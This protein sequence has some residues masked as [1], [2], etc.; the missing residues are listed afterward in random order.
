MT[1]LAELGIPLSIV[2]QPIRPLQ[3]TTAQAVNLDFLVGN[4]TTNQASGFTLSNPT[5]LA[6]AQRIALLLQGQVYSDP[7]QL[8]DLRAIYEN[9]FAPGAP[10]PPTAEPVQ[11][12]GGG[13]G[14]GAILA[15][16]VAA[17]AFGG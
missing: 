15:A 8:A 9:S 16:L 10:N 1:T 17:F 12:G 14:L 13:L 3:L 2:D 4:Y 11:T 5:Q 7:S 6:L